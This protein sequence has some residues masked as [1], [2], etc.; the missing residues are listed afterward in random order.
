MNRCCQSPLMDTNRFYKS[1]LTVNLICCCLATLWLTG[2]AKPEKPTETAATAASENTE[3]PPA[4]VQTARLIPPANSSPAAAITNELIVA[5][6]VVGLAPASGQYNQIERSDT[7]TPILA[8]ATTGSFALQESESDLASRKLEQLTKLANSGDSDAQLEIGN[9]YATGRHVEKAETVAHHWYQLAAGQGN[10]NAQYKLGLQYFHGKGVTKD[11]SIAREWWLE[12]ATQGNADAQQKLGYLYSEALGV[13]RDYDRAISWYKRAG[14][15]GHAEAQTL[16][17]SLYHEGNRIP[18]NYNEAFKWYKMAAE[19]GHPHAQY[20]LATLFHDG[21]GTEQNFI[22]CTAWVDVALANGYTDD[23]NARDE[24]RKHLS[25]AE[26]A[27][28]TTLAN[29]WKSSLLDRSGY[30]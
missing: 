4:A 1:P 29:R 15:L 12:A 18:R 22:K 23:F 9:T 16:L 30:N 19:R 26:L 7:D 10:H 25:E 13:E 2:C 17:G 27:E 24:C 20:T 6:T 5:D 8:A 28:A 11:Y 3:S 21:Y 14:Q